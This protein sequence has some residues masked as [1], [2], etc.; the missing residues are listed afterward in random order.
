MRRQLVV[1]AWSLTG[2]L[3]WCAPLTAQITWNITYA[4]PEGTGFYDPQSKDN[5]AGIRS[6]LPRSI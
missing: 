2:I 3:V 4:D 6:L 5:F 1:P